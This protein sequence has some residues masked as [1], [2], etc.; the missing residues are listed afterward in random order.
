V[1]KNS[2]KSGKEQYD[3]NDATPHA[4]GGRGRNRRLRV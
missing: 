4:A 1:E 2:L 3:R